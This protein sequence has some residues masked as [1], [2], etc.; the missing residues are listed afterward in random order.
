MSLKEK[1][2]EKRLIKVRG[3]CNYARYLLANME[4]TLTEIETIE[5]KEK[6]RVRE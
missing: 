5:A 3:S 1:D 4:K 6:R 2:I